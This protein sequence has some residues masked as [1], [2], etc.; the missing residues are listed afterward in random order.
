MTL[1]R[2]DPLGL[3]AYPITGSGLFGTVFRIGLSSASISVRCLS[4][5]APYSFVSPYSLFFLY[6]I[7]T[8]ATAG[9]QSSSSPR[10]PSPPPL[11]EVQIESPTP[12]VGGDSSGQDTEQSLGYIRDDNNDDSG[13]TRRVRPGSKAIDMA[14][15]PPLIP[16]AQVS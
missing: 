15:G 8:M 5:A 1:P 6:C 10:L 3:R 16:L 11:T 2:A 12:S 9:V 4:F 14:A 13:A 7:S